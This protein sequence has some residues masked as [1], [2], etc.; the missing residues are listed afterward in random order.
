MQAF[1][2]V[3]AS[4]EFIQ[5]LLAKSPMP[6]NQVAVIS[7]LS[8]TYIR[9]L[10]QG[11][12]ANVAREKLIALAVALNLDLNETDQMLNIF[13]RAP[14]SRQD[15][16]IFLQ[17]AEKGTITSAMLPVRDRYSLDLMMLAAE[18][19]P[20][21]HVVVSSE[22][23]VCLRAQG[24][25]LYS[26]RRLSKMHPIY[27][28]L[29]EAIG[30]ERRQVM[31]K[32]LAHHAVEQYI[33]KKCLEDYLLL[34]EDPVEKQWRLKHLQNV[35]TSLDQYENWHFFLTNSCPTFSFVL[36]TPS[37]E[38]RESEKLLI[39]RLAPHRF[40]GMRTGKL[41]GFTTDN[42]VVIQNF[43]D[44]LEGIRSAVH[45]QYLDRES[46]QDYLRSL[47]AD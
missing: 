35:L 8:N 31:D 12:I 43:K 16:P 25:R 21:V 47:M 41:T 11:I 27:G 39:T 38:T 46:L 26:E 3:K 14:L 10:E 6:R 30:D 13:D 20:G 1:D 7:G 36:K 28:E 24:H 32:N 19:L 34:C 18:R 2:R 22:P 33:C 45:E 5:E 37:P 17:T 29:V 4:A 15:I 23:T 40:Q 42:Q 9:D 44:E